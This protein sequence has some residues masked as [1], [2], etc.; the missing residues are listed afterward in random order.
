[1]HQ[2]FLLLNY[3]QLLGIILHP[4]AFEMFTKK[5]GSDMRF[6]FCVADIVE[7]KPTIKYLNYIDLATGL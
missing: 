7:I 3:C 1:L 5:Y 2:G 4:R 6:K